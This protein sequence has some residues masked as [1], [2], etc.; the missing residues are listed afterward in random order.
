MHFLHGLLISQ[1]QQPVVYYGTNI[2][3]SAYEIL[4]PTFDLQEPI[5]THLS[6]LYAQFIMGAAVYGGLFFVA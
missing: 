3:D 1:D 2:D 4:P 6:G 5:V